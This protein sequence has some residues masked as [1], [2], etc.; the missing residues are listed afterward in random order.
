MDTYFA[1]ERKLKDVNVRKI[2]LDVTSKMLY[3]GGMKTESKFLDIFR[4]Y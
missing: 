1:N 3:I 2:S 4:L